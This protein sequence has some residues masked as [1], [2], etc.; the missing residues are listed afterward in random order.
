MAPRQ[1]LALAVGLAAFV[2]VAIAAGAA[3]TGPVVAQ[4]AEEYSSVPLM[5]WRTN[6]VGRAVLKVGDTVY[7][8]GSFSHAVSPDGTQR[9][10]RANLAAFDV[11]T[12]ALIPTFRADTDGRVDELLFDGTSL[13][14][15]GSFRSIDGATRWRIA[16][17]D[18]ITGAVRPTFTADANSSVY[19]M[20]LAAG[21]LFVAGQFDEVNGVSRRGAAALSPV[22][23]AVDPDF[24]PTATGTVKAIAATPDASTVFIGGPYI[25]VNGDASARDIT[26]LDG[27]TGVI[28]P[29]RLRQVTG[30][31]DD[32]EVT[33]DGRHLIAGH[34]GVPGVGNRTAV[35][36]ITTGRREW[37]DIVDGD[38]QAVRL[39]GTTVWSGFHDG[40]DG[41]GSLRLRG[42][43]LATGD[44]NPAVRPHFDRFMGVWDVDGDGDALVVGGD[45]SIVSGTRVEGFAIFPAT[46]PTEFVASV[47]GSQPWQYLDDGTD[48]GTSWRQEGFDDRG[49]RSGL[50]E[51]GYGDGGERTRISYGS[52]PNDKHITTYFRTTFTAT[53]VPTDAAVYMRVDDGAVVYINGIEAVRDNMPSGTVDHETLAALRDG[54]AESSSRYSPIDPTLV[55][56]GTNTLAVEVHQASADSNDLSFFPTLV[57]I[58]GSPFTPPPTTPPPAPPVTSPSTPPA[59]AR[60]A[61]AAGTGSLDLRSAQ[62]WSV[63]LPGEPLGAGWNTAA[64]DD[65]PWRYA[66]APITTSSSGDPTLSGA[67]VIG[68]A[69]SRFTADPSRPLELIVRAVPGATV[70]VNGIAVID[71]PDPADRRPGT[72]APAVRLD[73]RVTLDA[74]FVT[75]GINIVAIRYDTG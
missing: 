54:G 67:G 74:R 41:D 43:D 71:F 10:G 32:L 46:G 25:D 20:S 53:A 16:A 12:G 61:A 3:S 35:Y 52:N 49:W 22:S 9:V 24:A 15:A 6:G 50:G 17:I 23:G 72:I 75:A 69:R 63:R 7:V 27:E 11:R 57:A 26:A 55:R 70:F 56:A 73:R 36:D 1:W 44:V 38:V 18:P 65:A 29:L 4:T 59:S 62:P 42:Y 13:F 51:F 33:P 28:S 8:G 40:A 39:I 48:Q 64:F 2:G 31:V 60:A 30:F 47:L 19:S 58:A 45:F 5:S 14:V 21:R 68:A 37:R 34:S 66:V